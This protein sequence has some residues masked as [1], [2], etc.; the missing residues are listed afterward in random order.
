MLFICFAASLSFLRWFFTCRWSSSWVISLS[1]SSSS[2]RLIRCHMVSGS[3]MRSHWCS[4]TFMPIRIRFCALIPSSYQCANCFFR[5]S[6][7]SG[8]SGFSK[9]YSFAF[10]ISLAVS[11]PMGTAQSLHLRWRMS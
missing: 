1:P 3:I 7:S 6:S 9:M 2:V 8:A 5:R 4:I 11:A 10:R